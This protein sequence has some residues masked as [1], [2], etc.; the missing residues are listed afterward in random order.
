MNEL[1]DAKLFESF[2]RIKRIVSNGNPTS[3]TRINNSYGLHE[4]YLTIKDGRQISLLETLS[5]MVIYED[6]FSNTLN[7][8]VEVNDIVSG[9]SKFYITGGETL[10]M[11]IL[12]PSPSAEIL[13]GRNDFIIHQISK[14]SM[15]DINSLSYRL[16]FVSKSGIID[17]KK[18][19]YKS[20][21]KEKKLSEIISKLY[22]QVSS[23]NDISLN[24]E[25]EDTKITLEKPFLCPGYTPFEA[26]DYLVKRTSYGGDYY[27]FF[28]RLIKFREKTHVFG[29]LNFLND[30]WKSIDYVPTILYQPQRSHITS[31][32]SRYLKASSVEIQDNFSHAGNMMSG[33]YNSRLRMLD[34]LIRR[35][36]DAKINYKDIRNSSGSPKFLTDDNIFMSYDDSYPE[37]PGERL[38]VRPRHDILANKSQWVRND[39]YQSILLSTIRVN[40]EIAGAD[41]VISAGNIVNLTIPDLQDKNDDYSATVIR[42]DAVYSGTYFV[43]AVQHIFTLSD[44]VKRLELS[45]DTGRLNLERLIANVSNAA[46][47]NNVEFID[48]SRNSPIVPKNQSTPISFPTPQTSVPSFVPNAPNEQ[49]YTVYLSRAERRYREAMESERTYNYSERMYSSYIEEEAQPIIPQ[50]ETVTEPQEVTPPA[51]EEPKFDLQSMLPP[52][53]STYGPVQKIAWFNRYKISSEVL[54]ENGVAQPDIDWMQQNGYKTF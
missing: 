26:I 12:K 19:V 29:G 16:F 47:P 33:F 21:T 11:K 54:L 23:S 30:H 9:L 14:V 43:T 4:L 18:R 49:E 44:Y 41:N 10:S 34:P 31:Q 52:D 25:D 3:G 42:P 5:S 13:F 8:Y 53:W 36:S 38:F 1:F 28:E 50:I 7:G 17:K 20:F 27:M 32:D 46:P 2:D 48:T 40:V 51:I 15:N 45:K 39:V 22:S 24:I 37:F 6:V 35:F